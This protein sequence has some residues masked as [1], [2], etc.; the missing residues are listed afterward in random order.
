MS[1]GQNMRSLI[2]KLFIICIIIQLSSLMF[3]SLCFRSVMASWFLSLL[4]FFFSCNYTNHRY[5]TCNYIHINILLQKKC[6]VHST[7][8]ILL[9]L[10][11]CNIS[12]FDNKVIFQQIFDFFYQRKLILHVFNFKSCYLWSILIQNVMLKIKYLILSIKA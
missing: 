4:L 8:Y 12:E 3:N 11:T 2:K 6:N 5:N 9:T 10:S 7:R 1:S